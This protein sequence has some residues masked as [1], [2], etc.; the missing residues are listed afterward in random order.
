MDLSRSYEVLYNF[1]GDS[2]TGVYSGTRPECELYLLDIMKPEKYKIKSWF[3]SVLFG[4]GL[5][6][7]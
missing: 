6:G 2:W 5:Y 1:E 3:Q 4:E 7:A